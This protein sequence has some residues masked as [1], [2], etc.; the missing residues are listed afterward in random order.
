MPS[1]Y[2]NGHTHIY[3]LEDGKGIFLFKATWIENKISVFDYISLYSEKSDGINRNVH[4]CTLYLRAKKKGRALGE[5]RTHG[6]I[7]RA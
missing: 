6:T 5:D 2:C 1:L 4:L 3:F 7:L